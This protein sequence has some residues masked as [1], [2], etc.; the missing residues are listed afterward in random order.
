M[1]PLLIAATALLAILQ[2]L[3]PRKWAF[4]PILIAC[5]HLGDLEIIPNLTPVRI[6]ILCGLIRAGI[7]GTLVFKPTCTLDKAFYVFST[8][9]LLV[10][11]APRLDIPSPISQ[12]LGLILNVHGTY[13]YGRSLL[14]GDKLIERYTI[15][16]ILLLLPLAA[17]L[18]FEQ[19]TRQNIYYHLGARA[20][21]SMV[22]GDR[23]RALGPFQH[24]ILSGTVGAAA[25][26]FALILWRRKKIHGI[27]GIGASL[28]IVVSS[29][30]SGPMAA[31]I[32]TAA[33]LMVWP[34]RRWL[35]MIQR[36]GLVM[37][38]V[39]HLIST[40]GIWYLM[41]RMDLAGGSTGYHRAKLIDSAINDFGDW[42]LFGTDYTRNWMFS[43]VS[44]SSRHTDITNYYLQFGVTGG[45]GLLLAFVAI[46]YYGFK[47]YG[48]RL[49]ATNFENSTENFGLWCLGCSLVA[50]ATS[51]LSVAYFDQ[52]YANLFMLIALGPA[53]IN[54]QSS[55]AISDSDAGKRE[56]SV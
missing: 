13:L 30:S 38:F 1:P 14:V 35:S 21:S 27:V 19:R 17:L 15:A 4:T 18:T 48:I 55:S 51:F 26:P 54:F 2:F 37:V 5:F 46:L 7:S 10:S 22:R 47:T 25:L 42:W 39:L 32:V 34:A 20:D 23:N 49:R 28:A 44:W 33:A 52:S 50:H 3:I 29:A 36:I 31:A 24:A 40:R 53:I 11:A 12:N 9:A 45:M 56:Q 6:M 16:M 43:G 41:A 8:I